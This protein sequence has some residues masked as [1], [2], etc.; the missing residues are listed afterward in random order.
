MY[1]TLTADALSKR[2]GFGIERYE[3]SEIQNNVN[4]VYERMIEPSFWKVINADK[5]ED[6]LSDELE[7][8]IREKINDVNNEPLKLLW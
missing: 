3:T 4:K 8:L 7:N 1:L 6:E 2:G 5:K